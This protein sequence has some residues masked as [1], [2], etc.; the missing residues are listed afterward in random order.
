MWISSDFVSFCFDME[1]SRTPHSIL[2]LK[3]PLQMEAKRD[4][5]AALKI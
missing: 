5:K 4:K 1:V 3:I 2:P